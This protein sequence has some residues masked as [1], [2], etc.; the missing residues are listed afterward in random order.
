MLSSREVPS[1]QEIA[2]RIGDKTLPLADASSNTSMDDS[3]PSRKTRSPKKQ[4]SDAVAFHEKRKAEQQSDANEHL[5]EHVWCVCAERMCACAVDSDFG[6]GRALYFDSKTWNPSS[7]RSST[8]HA[9]NSPAAGPMTLT[10]AAHSWEATL[11]M[12]GQYSTVE[13]F[14]NVFRTL[15]RPSQLERNSN[16]HLFKDGIKPMWEDPANAQGGKWV[17]TLRGS[18]TALLDRSWMW[19]V[20]AL[21]G[22]DMDEADE[23]TGAV[24][25]LRAKGDR[26]SLWIRDRD[27][28]N[29]VNRIGRTF[30]SLLNVEKEAGMSLEF[31]PNSAETTGDVSAQYTSIHNPLPAPSTIPFLAQ[32]SGPPLDGWHATKDPQHLSV[33]PSMSASSLRT[34]GSPTKSIQKSPLLHRSSGWRRPDGSPQPPPLGEGTAKT[35][36]LG[37]S[38]G[39][40]AHIGRTNSSSPISRAKTPSSSNLFAKSKIQA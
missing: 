20:L 12:L 27:D 5:L 9:P 29:K 13:T 7:S 37:F 40:G 24:V 6:K 4:V 11:R 31:A 35:T 26:I 28:V 14:M 34:G 22:E 32:P 3:L 1:L 21:I 23:V 10:S 17:L 19:L 36:G 16:Y 8:S 39:L 30:V 25:S 33:S 18:N 15:R 38:L 2:K